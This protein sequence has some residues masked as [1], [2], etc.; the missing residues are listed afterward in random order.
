M[1]VLVGALSLG[2]FAV[3][4][5]AQVQTGSILVKAIDQQGAV[6]P[7]T[8]I[9]ISSPALV[10][11]QVG[12]TDAS[13]VFRFLSLPPGTYSVKF[14]LSSFQTVVRQGIIVSVGQTTPLDVTLK[15]ASV[16]ETLT[17]TGQS[18]T[19]DTTSA[20][21]AVTLSSQLMQSTPN[22][23]DI[24]SLV[25]YKV[26]G[27]ISS[28][29]DVGGTSGGLQGAMVARGTPNSQNVQYLNGVN[30][31]DPSAVGYAGFY[32]DYGSFDEVQVSTGAQD[33]TVPSGGVFVNMVTKSGTDQFRGD[34]S[35]FWEGS[36]TQS[37]NVDSTLLNLGFKPD[38]NKTDFVSDVNVNVGG[39]IIRNKLRFFGSFRDWRVHVNVPAAFSESVLDQTNI[40]SGLGNFT[41]Q[42]NDKNRVTAFYAR[43]YYKKPDR[44]LGSSPFFTSQ[45]NSNE[46]DKFDIV[47]GLWNSV[48]SNHFFMD[49]RVSF[50]RIFF[51]LYFN[52]NDQTLL[53]LTTSIRTRN[54]L[55]EYV[56]IRKRLQS[57]ATFNYYVDQA[58][59]GRHEFRFGVDN[60][61][62]PTSTEVHRLDDLSLT[63]FSSTGASRSVTF[64]NSPNDSK[65]NLNVFALYFQDS[66]TA[67]RLSL[68]GGVRWERVE[69]YLPAQSS[70][71]SK[72]FPDA[73]RSFSPVRDAPLW[74]DIG[75]RV[76]A[77]YDLFGDGSTALKFSAARYYYMIST[78]T[79]NN[80]NPN[81]SVSKTYAWNDAN[82][83]LRFQD[84][85]QVGT[86]TESGG[87][88][89][90]FD[91][92]FRRPYTN[93]ITA[94]LDREVLPDL[95][96]SA[97]YTYRVER[98]PQTSINTA[99]PFS[100]WVL[101]SA[102]DPGPDGLI[103]TA[104]DGT[105]NYYDRTIPGNQ[106]LITNDPTSRQTY[107]G[108]E[109]TATKRFSRRWQMLAGYTY[110]RTTLR[111]L[112][113]GASPND[114]L[115]AEGP[116]TNSGGSSDR[117]QAFKLTGNYILPYDITFGANLRV[118][119]GPPINRRISAPLSFGGSATV[120]IEPPGAHR[121]PAL[122][123][124][125][126]RLGKI[127]Q[128]GPSHAFEADLD[129]FN[130]TNANTAWEAYSLTGRVS[131]HQGGNASAPLLN[132]QE[133]MTPDQILAPRIIRFGVSYRF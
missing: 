82:H 26:P 89:T 23:R 19:V 125:D 61:H 105:Y 112:S 102:V 44:F 15:V 110:A 9:T 8:T 11:P 49:A 14:E 126:L 73:Q 115:N 32:Y 74:H 95:K 21:V 101:T 127:F 117:P 94:G 116:V 77:I 120:N 118:Q 40:T 93:E 37:R 119:S 52:G 87:L 50:N 20:N 130:L 6:L 16:S 51:P 25:E 99:S 47:Q 108:I 18:P 68:V 96:L 39:P 104:D 58:L 67:R 22:G 7:G 57:S 55:Q 56:F 69:S 59:G 53:D 109:I 46:D 28:R 78:G 81:F 1:R 36:G 123:T 103:G 71:P 80:I 114:L 45:S 31:G 111:D 128:M 65:A 41:Y 13:G 106:T 54:A 30:V 27:L 85:E 62:M 3:P 48:M 107:K 98:Y 35:F 70:P 133:F 83:D 88:T 124:V 75:P 121:L 64:Y 17:V 132:L 129:I 131:V 113:L 60:S 86:P 63:Y 91:P 5:R 4:A 38:T 33:I 122:K 66:Y 12:T 42:L 34:G 90:S 92:N 24:W 43:Q 97:V 76:S 100:T 2:L 84:G 10:T 29:P 79:A 72:W